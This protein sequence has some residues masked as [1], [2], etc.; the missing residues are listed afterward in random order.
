MTGNAAEFSLKSLQN[1][2]MVDRKAQLPAHPC[3]SD[4]AGVMVQFKLLF[5]HHKVKLI[6]MFNWNVLFVQQE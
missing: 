1:S 4:K 6:F 5:G 2:S 3:H